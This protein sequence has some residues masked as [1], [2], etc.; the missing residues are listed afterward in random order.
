MSPAATRSIRP[1]LTPRSHPIAMERPAEVIERLREA[2]GLTQAEACLRGGVARATWGRVES[3]ST[4]NPHPATKIR[5]A[6][7]LEVTPSSIWRIRPGPLHLEDIDDPRWEAATRAMARRLDRAGSLE[8][9][10][11]F[12]DRLVA[13]LDYADQGS[14]GARPDEG[15]WDELWQLGSS[16]VFDPESTPITIVDGRLVERD[17]DGFTPATRIRVIAAKRRRMRAQSGRL[18]D[19]VAALGEVSQRR[20]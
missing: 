11:R 3:G 20:R 6:R 13:V 12:G 17:L 7:A 10:Q 9:R 4:A 18:R 1:S 16:L 14:T 2:L 8:E 15:R 19:L 5:I